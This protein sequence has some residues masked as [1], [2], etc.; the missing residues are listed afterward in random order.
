[1]KKI[2]TIC[3]IITVVI[4]MPSCKKSLN[5][6]LQKAPGVDVNEDAVFSSKVN[7]DAFVST[8]YEYGMFSILPNRQN[9]AIISNPSTNAIPSPIGT[10][11]AATDE[12]K[13]ESTFQFANV[14]NTAT[15]TNQSIIG[16]EDYRYYARWKA[17][18]MANI[19]LE[20]VDELTD[21][22]A[23][24]AYKKQVKAQAKF[25]RA[26]QN[27]EMLK[28]YGGI[29]LVTRRFTTVDS[30]YEQAILPR[31]TFAECVN[32]I[33][34]DCDEAYPDLEIVYPSAQK[35]RV[36]KLSALALKSRTL[37]YAASPMFNTATPYLSMA[38]PA[39]NKFICYGNF[40]K[41]RWKLAADAAMEVLTFAAPSGISLIDVPANRK[42]LEAS[43]TG[44]NFL[45]GNYRISWERQ[46]NTEII[47]ADKSNS[48]AGN[49]F[50]FPWQNIMPQDMGGFYGGTSV[51][52]NFM[53]KYED[54][55]GRVV[56]WSDAGGNDLQAK[57][58]SLDPRFKQSIGYNNSRWNA[59]HPLI[60]AYAGGKHNRLNWGGQWMLKP[61]P[62][63]IATGSVVPS[64]PMFR[65][66]EFFLNY[67][68][69]I[70]EF[71]GPGS[72]SVAA[73]AEPPNIPTSAYDAVNRIR[74]RSGMPKI[75][76]G[77]TA[78]QFRVRVRNERA[79][80]LAFE[81]H[82]FWDI[83]RWLIAEDEGVMKGAMFGIK[84]TKLDA[85]T[86]KYVP[87]L[88]ENRSFNKN[89]YLHPFDLNEV[90]KGK[91]VQNPGW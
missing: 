40:D 58:G 66:N 37:L 16:S 48:A 30:A 73:N 64:L 70:N 88:I 52:L 2:I 80:E 7:V 53:K 86:F 19:L 51:L 8:L 14:W 56:T 69:A 41:N 25:M 29:P 22:A 84:I 75:P 12:G 49:N 23:D 77:L 42:P 31:S 46:D 68:E 47:L 91:L 54:T 60:E 87:Y 83:R 61:A 10:L 89:M 79:I 26:L 43:V 55:L 45:N 34:K 82:R 50:S 72:S 85:T 17:I 62:E 3:T 59:S 44:T 11:A 76:A 6:F 90:L 81:D 18:R 67:A 21:P 28:R 35:G 20:R 13:N 15:V 32:A 5:D 39:N 1:M 24:A 71:S 74:A 33:L 9:T 78:D 38:D 57:Y 36:T 27:F 65:L 63:G 4:M